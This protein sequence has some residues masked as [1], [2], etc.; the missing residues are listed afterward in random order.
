MKENRKEARRKCTRKNTA[1]DEIHKATNTNV[2]GFRSSRMRLR[3]AEGSVR[4][5]YR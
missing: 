3:V 4:D 2:V 1:L 5:V